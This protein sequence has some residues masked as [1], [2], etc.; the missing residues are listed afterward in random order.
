MGGIRGASLSIPVEVITGDVDGLYP[1]GH[2]FMVGLL[3]RGVVVIV[4]P[5]LVPA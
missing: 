1:G 4:K 5:V 3:Q 2:Q